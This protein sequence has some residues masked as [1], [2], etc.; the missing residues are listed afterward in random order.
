[1][2]VVRFIKV[3]SSAPE[4]DWAIDP[5]LIAEVAP[6]E[7]YVNKYT[8]EVVADHHCR[9]TLHDKTVVWL[10]E[11]FETVYTLINGN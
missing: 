7:P 2:S 8:D 1:M 3:S 9:I 4:M 6:V 11:D 5:N 10:K